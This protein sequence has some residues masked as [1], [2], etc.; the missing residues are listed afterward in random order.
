MT[1]Q[2][3]KS[4]TRC[5]EV[6]IAGRPNVGKSTLLNAFLGVHLAATSSKPQ[7]TRNRILG[8]CTTLTAQY[9]FIDTP[10]IHLGGKRL[11]NQALNKTAISTLPDARVLMFVVEAGKWTEEDETVLEHIRKVKCPVILV[12]NKVDKFEDKAAILP[13]VQGLQEKFDFAEI[14]PVSAFRQR[15]VNYLLRHLESYLPEAE[16]VY[17]EDEI[18]DR[19]MRFIAAEMVR[20]QLTQELAQELPYSLAVEIEEY[21][22]TPERVEIGAVIYVE[23]E[24]QKG[25]VIGNQGKMLKKIGTKA[26][27]R[28]ISLLDKRV[29]LELWVKVKGGWQD[30]ANLLSQ[31][32]IDN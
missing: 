8:I 12:V 31:F 2:E 19:N 32:G 9:I 21:K 28:L 22:E 5:G 17:G 26:R 25:I 4:V 30:N 13:Y 24:G 15:N 23:R 14:I 20:E 10:G 3:E 11:L 1:T 7:T 29:H 6:V 18:T 16:F 27:K